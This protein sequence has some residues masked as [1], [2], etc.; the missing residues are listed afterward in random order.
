MQSEIFRFMTIRPPQ[1]VD[2]KTETDNTVDL[3]ETNSEL[4][5]LLIGQKNA[6]SRAEIE[7]LVQIFF[8]SNAVEFID[9]RKKVSSKFIAFYDTV[10]KLNDR[11]FLINAKQSFVRIFNNEP[12]KIIGSEEYRQLSINITNCCRNRPK[13]RSEGA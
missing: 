13:C 4:I 2:S 3:D 7:K 9:S 11:D 1:A 12:Q 10:L 6:G 8:K 5:K